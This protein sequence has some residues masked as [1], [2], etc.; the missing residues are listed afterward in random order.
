MVSKSNKPNQWA[1][2]CFE[3]TSSTL[4]ERDTGRSFE[5]KSELFQ[6]SIVKSK[7]FEEMRN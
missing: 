6:Q 5:R 4:S 3:R 7:S 2:N 1:K